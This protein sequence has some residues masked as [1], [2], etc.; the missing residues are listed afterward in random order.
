MVTLQ[1]NKILKNKSRNIKYLC[2]ITF[3]GHVMQR[4]QWHGLETGFK[5][6]TAQLLLS[7]SFPVP[8]QLLSHTHTPPCWPLHTAQPW[9]VTSM[10]THGRVRN[11]ALQS[12]SVGS[13]LPDKLAAVP[14]PITPSGYS[15][16]ITV[17]KGGC[18]SPGKAGEAMEALPGNGPHHF[19]STRSQIHPYLNICMC[20]YF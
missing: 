10:D 18:K 8:H 4:W 12:A 11:F 14:H 13:G 20:K 1:N 9:S 5:H 17:V 3:N 16:P 2:F 15:L 7:K 6:W 19:G